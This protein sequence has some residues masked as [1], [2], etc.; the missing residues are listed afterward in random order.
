MSDGGVLVKSLVA[1]RSGDGRVEMAHELNGG[2]W[3]LQMS[4]PEARDLALNLLQGAEAAESDA[5]F[6]RFAK[7]RLH[8]SDHDAQLALLTFRKFRE[9]SEGGNEPEHR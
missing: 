3:S 7:E 2:G 8:A 6:Y 5:R 9:D 1:S 4:A